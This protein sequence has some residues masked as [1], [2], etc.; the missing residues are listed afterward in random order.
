MQMLIQRQKTAQIQQKNNTIIHK[1]VEE[2][3]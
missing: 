2:F 3:S 1:H